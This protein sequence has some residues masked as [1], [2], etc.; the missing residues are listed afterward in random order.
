MK[1]HGF[2]IQLFHS[3]SELCRG[4]K[5][6]QPFPVPSGL[7][8]LVLSDGARGAL[9]GGGVGGAEPH[10]HLQSPVMGTLRA[11]GPKGLKEPQE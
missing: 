8:A 6:G 10:P 1:N 5:K 9:A 7:L 11:Q 3:F 4:S 2:K